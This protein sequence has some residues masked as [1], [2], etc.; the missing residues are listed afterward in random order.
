MHRLGG[1]VDGLL[2]RAAL[3]IDG[4]ARNGVGKP[5]GQRGVAADVHGLLA[6]GHRAARR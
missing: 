3:A 4:G 2:G 1:E 6:D 5:G